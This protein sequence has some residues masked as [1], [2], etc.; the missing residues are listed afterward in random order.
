MKIYLKLLF[1]CLI[2]FSCATQAQRVERYCFVV[3]DK[4]VVDSVSKMYLNSELEF[5]YKRMYNSDGTFKEQGLFERKGSNSDAV[6]FKRVNLDWYVKNKERWDAFYITSKQISPVVSLA[7][8]KIQLIFSKKSELYGLTC[9]IFKYTEVGKQTGGQLYYWF[10][11]EKGIVLIQADD[12]ELIR[13]DILPPK[14]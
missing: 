9:S 8:K 11:A 6:E 14:Q 1:L 12:V 2:Y 5:S 10:N 4:V 7:G 13:K 3:K